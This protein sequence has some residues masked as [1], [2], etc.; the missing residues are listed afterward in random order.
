MV[1]AGRAVMR[2][3]VAWRI[4]GG[5]AFV[6]WAA[7]WRCVRRSLRS[8]GLRCR[9]AALGTRIVIVGRNG[10]RRTAGAAVWALRRRRRG[11]LTARVRPVLLVRHHP[12]TSV[13]TLR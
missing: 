3:S 6:T 8:L 4:S 9:R 7:G 11:A 12:L 2:R 10:V 13:R 1:L 5:S